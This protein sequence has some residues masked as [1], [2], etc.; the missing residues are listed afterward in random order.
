MGTDAANTGLVTNTNALPNLFG[1]YNVGASG[2]LSPLPGTV[3]GYYVARVR[4]IDQSGNQ[5]NPA[6]PN[7]QVPF[8]VDNTPPTATFTSPTAGQVVTSLTNGVL[9]FTITTSKNIDLTHFNASSIVAHQRGPRRHPRHRRRR[10]DPDQSHLDLGHLPRQGNRR[11]GRRT[12]L[13]LDSSQ[14]PL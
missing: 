6:D 3:S 7:A 5:S 11:P 1:T 2:D 8:V 14:G 4:I 9:S 13:V 12:D 10:H